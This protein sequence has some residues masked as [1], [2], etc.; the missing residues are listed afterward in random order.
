MTQRS[1]IA[2]I[3]LSVA[4]APLGS[5]GTVRAAA[6]PL[7]PV[8]RADLGAAALVPENVSCYS[9]SLHILRRWKSIW[10]SHAVQSLVQLPLVQQFW[11]GAQQHPFFLGAVQ[12]AQTNPLLIEGLP[13]LKDAIATEAFVCT[14]PDLPPFLVAA[15]RVYGSLSGQGIKAAFAQ[16]PQP[17][18]PDLGAVLQAVI[19]QGEQLRLPTILIGF[20]LSNPA[21]AQKFLDT[22]L[23]RVGPLF[24]GEIQKLPVGGQD[25]YVLELRGDILPRADLVQMDSDLARESIPE[26]TRKQFLAWLTGQRIVVALGLVGDYLLLSLGH[27]TALL[28]QWGQGRSL[29]ESAALEPLRA[30][31]KPGFMDLTYTS[32]ELTDVFLPS[33]EG[34]QRAIET[35]LQAVPENERTAL[36][37]QRIRAEAT[38][39]LANTPV[40]RPT[41]SLTFSFENHGVEVFGFPALPPTELDC[42]K[43]LT[44]LAHRGQHPIACSATRAAPIAD[45]YGIMTQ[46]LRVAFLAFEG[47]G[48]PTMEPQDRAEYEKIMKLLRPFL[49]SVDETT[50]TCLI[51]AV[52]GT[53]SLLVLDGRG[54]LT[55]VPG[56]PKP[57]QPVPLWRL[58]M[59]ME[60]ND[61]A[62][63]LDAI[64]GYGQALNTLIQAAQAAYPKAIP[65][66]LKIPPP[67]SADAQGGKLYFYRL[68]A[69]LGPDV[70]PC[71]VIKDRLLIVASSSALAREMVTAVPMPTDP[72][73]ALDRPAGA[74]ALFQADE[75]WDFGRRLT[76]A[77]LA[78]ILRENRGMG[79][80]DRMMAMAIQMHLDALWRALGA[81]RSYASTTTATPDEGC[82]EHSWLHV[83]DI[84]P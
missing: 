13:V 65:P 47:F 45:G 15:A 19:T 5:R 53:Q 41:R 4:L 38:R 44:I 18:K 75:A 43:P 71:A 76:H 31:H 29:A 62:K 33:P 73:V 84:G 66:A 63:F 60:L 10:E 78:L 83:E 67:E 82:L 59:A 23:P 64:R 16:G 20:K 34:I 28:T 11:M 50:R 58:G 61:T 12:A 39:L 9:S 57:P 81:I 36:V 21:A 22:W 26:A 51:P 37:K 2:A 1:W 32:A 24:I 48:V 14:G 54:A 35:L 3:V 7:S 49:A 17:P 42:S 52:D 80:G 8:M 70:F 79:D 56:A 74:A 27:D 55:E 46:W 6:T 68:P 72:V 40:L 25:M 30:R 77:V 69:A